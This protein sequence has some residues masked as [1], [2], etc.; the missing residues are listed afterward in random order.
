MFLLIWCWMPSSLQRIVHGMNLNLRFSAD[1][2]SLFQKV[3]QSKVFYWL[4]TGDSCCSKLQ[5]ARALKSKKCQ[6]EISN[7]QNG[8]KRERK[9]DH[10]LLHI[11]HSSLFTGWNC[12]IFISF[13]LI[14]SSLWWVEAAACR[15]PQRCLYTWDTS[16][17]EPVC[18]S[19]N[20]CRPFSLCSLCSVFCW[21]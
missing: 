3:F 4:L 1:I 15:S 17:P 2:Q 20:W 10:P 14:L 9:S 12:I 18:R 6:A 19:R 13:P 21:I 7:K 16:S 11:V 5:K 8:K